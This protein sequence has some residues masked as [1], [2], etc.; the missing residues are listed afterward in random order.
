[1][2]ETTSSGRMAGSVIDQIVVRRCDPPSVQLSYNGRDG[3][4]TNRGQP[5]LLLD[6]RDEVHGL[7]S[8][9]RSHR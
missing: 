7:A 2:L 1:M 5:L 4:I 8:A 9:S 3:N 6:S